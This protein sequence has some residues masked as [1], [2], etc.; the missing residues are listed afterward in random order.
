MY[1][2]VHDLVDALIKFTLFCLWSS[3]VGATPPKGRNVFRVEEKDWRGTN[4]EVQEEEEDWWE[5]ASSIALISII[6]SILACLQAQ[7]PLLL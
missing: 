5:Y 4:D 3:V 1:I 6:I 7:L 2:V